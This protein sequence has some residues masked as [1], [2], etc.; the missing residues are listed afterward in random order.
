PAALRAGNQ[1]SCRPRASVRRAML[2]SRASSSRRASSRSV[3]ESMCLPIG[4]L[5][6]VA[7]LLLP[8]GALEH[9]ELGFAEGILLG[10]ET[11]NESIT[12]VPGTKTDGLH[13]LK[14]LPDRGAVDA[15]CVLPKASGP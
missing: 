10:G 2:A 6:G 12:G 8:E 4:G 9:V 11:I 15:D 3:S 1:P 5:G 14:E 7:S 13:G